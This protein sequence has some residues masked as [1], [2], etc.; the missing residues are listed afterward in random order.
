MRR[1]TRLGRKALPGCIRASVAWL[2]LLALALPGY[3]SVRGLCCA[4]E[5]V[6]DRPDC[7][8][9]SIGDSGNM[10]GMESSA[11]RST[12][13][14]STAANAGSGLR[15][16]AECA[17]VPAAEGPE[18]VVQ[19][20]RFLNQK[21][22]PARGNVFGPGWNR[23]AEVRSGRPLSSSNMDRTPPGGSSFD[24]LSIALRI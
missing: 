21:L 17:P 6:Q 5:G 4:P 23:E 11:T 8:S 22:L 7:C 12:A 16:I 14:L 1:E 10:P 3:A 20:E 13:A 18:S 2:V 19:G 24:P 9:A 15:V